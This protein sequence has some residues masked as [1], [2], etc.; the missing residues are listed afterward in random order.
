MLV[1]RPTLT[2]GKHNVRVSVFT[3]DQTACAAFAQLLQGKWKFVCNPT[4]A[5]KGNE[6]VGF[7]KRS[8]CDNRS[9]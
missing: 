4:T 6:I 8:Q 5:R 9:P 7:A 3:A 1:A 2:A